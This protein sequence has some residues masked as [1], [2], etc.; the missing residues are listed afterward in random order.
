M[1]SHA[2]KCRDLLR[3]MEQLIGC[4]YM[5]WPDGGFTNGDVSTRVDGLLIVW[6]ADVASLER[7]VEIGCNVVLCHEPI[8]FNIKHELP[9]YRWLN[10]APEAGEPPF[11]TNRRRRE[12]IEDNNLTVLQCH[13]G[14]DRY[15][16]FQVFHETLG[17][18]T[19]CFD[20]GWE[21]VF[22]VEPKTTLGRLAGNVRDR[23]GFDGPMRVVGDRDRE[24]SRVAFLW[25]GM[26]LSGNLYWLVEVIRNG[27]N[28][29]ICGEMDEFFMTFAKDADFP[30]IETSHRLSEEV[31]IGA[32][33]R[34][35]KKVCP[36]MR[37]EFFQQGRPYGWL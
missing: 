5:H 30:V 19:P 32:Y 31:G 16:L 36:G 26:G 1:R 14:L 27:A 12:I 20:K 17:F 10:P 34:H 28:A 11:H 22:P 3:P 18:S 37:L 7:A 21:S 24:I 35:L 25:G 15:C 33:A 2:Y 29:G 13:Y 8:Y 23:L 9:P 6:M 4:D